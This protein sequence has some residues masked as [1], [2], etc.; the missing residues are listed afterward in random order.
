MKIKT[1][2]GKINNCIELCNYV[3]ADIMLQKFQR[4]FGNR[5]FKYYQRLLIVNG[6]W[7]T[8]KCNC[9]ACNTNKGQ[10]WSVMSS[11]K[12]CGNK[13]CPGA[14][15]HLFQHLC[16]NSNEPNQLHSRYN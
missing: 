14:T 10:Q 7:E 11:C 1:A 6:L 16:K 15:N 5:H 3:E 4:K 13:R 2:I 8:H 12:L 9:Y